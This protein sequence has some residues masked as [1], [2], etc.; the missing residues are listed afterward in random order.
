MELLII[1]SDRVGLDLAMRAA[2]CD[3][4]VRLFRYSQKPNKYATGFPQIKLVDDWREH[5][6][7]ARNGLILLTAN[8][9]YVT[10][11]DRWREMGYK[12]IFSPTVASAKLEIV[13]SAGMDAIRASGI[14]IPHYETFD[15]LEDAERFARKSDRAW[16][17]KPAGDEES[18]QLTYVSRDPAD[19][20]GWLRRQIVL[21]KKLKGKILLQEKIEKLA[22]LGVS[23]WMG[24]DGFLPDKVQICHEH[25]PLYAGDIGMNTGEQGSITQYTDVEKLA[26]ELL[27]PL[28]P[29]FLALGHRGDTAV[30]AMIDTKGKSHFLEFT[31]RLGYPAFWLQ[32]ASHKGDPISWMRDA[33]IGHDTL[34][35]SMDA[36]AGVV[37]SQPS[38][39][40]ESAPPEQVEGIPIQGADEVLPDLHL[41]EAMRGKGPVWENGRVVEKPVFETAGEYVAVATGLGKT[42]SKAM[43]RVYSTVDKVRFPDMG[44]RNEIGA[45]L[46]KELPKLHA[47]GYALDVKW[48]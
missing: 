36:A 32:L 33:L 17:V 10:E 1:D 40:F 16:V 20:T 30:G 13:R 46:E 38:Y 19:L 2:E 47:A 35:V 14:D 5:M 6:A 18:K 31:C 24:A 42:V 43:K 28:E 29:V 4:S 9:R 44:Y 25:K 21:G 41:V 11:L 37:L 12:N 27:L 34:K 45:R 48:D 7:W 39:P 22:E 26:N 3:H 23:A 8:N 15:S